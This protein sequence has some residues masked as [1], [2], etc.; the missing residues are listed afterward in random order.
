[1]K[2]WNVEEDWTTSDHRAITFEVEERTNPGR[3]ETSRIKL[4]RYNTRKADWALF[5]QA[6][7]SK[8]NEVPRRSAKRK[9]DVIEKV[10][11]LTFALRKATNTAIPRQ[12]KTVAKVPWWNEEIESLRKKV[13]QSRRKAQREKD[14]E[15]RVRKEE[16]HKTI[17][18]EYAKLTKRER[19]ERFKARATADFRENPWGPTYRLRTGK[20]KGTEIRSNLRTNE[21]AY[22]SDW[23]ESTNLSLIHI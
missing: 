22:T 15:E 13:T 23:E 11:A 4:K 10:R 12:Y 18:G 6:L 14:P 20:I 21:G 17:A 16:V 1:M 8:W 2:D 5:E 7:R 19:E 9:N 3:H